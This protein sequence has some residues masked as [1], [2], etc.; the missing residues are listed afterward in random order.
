MII[1]WLRGFIPAV[2]FSVFAEFAAC[3]AFR[4]PMRLWCVFRCCEWQRLVLYRCLAPK[5]CCCRVDRQQSWMSA[6]NDV[7]SPKGEF[8]WYFEFISVQINRKNTFFSRMIWF[9]L[10]I[11]YYF[12]DFYLSLGADNLRI[13]CIL[14]MGLGIPTNMRYKQIQSREYLA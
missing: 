13:R 9:P 2:V 4:P 1:W 11:W 5:V 6:F 8:R 10:R 12:C 14:E 3:D 7:M